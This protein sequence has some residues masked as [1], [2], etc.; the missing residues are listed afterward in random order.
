[1]A[2]TS[3]KVT[4]TT[5]PVALTSGSPTVVRVWNLGGVTVWL[6]PTGAGNQRYPV[7]ANEE[8]VI[9][10]L[11]NDVLFA[12]VGTGDPASQVAVFYSV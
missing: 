10:L 5:T 12:S 6:G 7:E 9:N 11:A 1:M 2:I 4:V 3:N 8:V